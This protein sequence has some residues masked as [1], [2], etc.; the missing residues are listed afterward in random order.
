MILQVLIAMIAGWINRHQ[1]Q[2]IAYLLEEN[3]TLHAKLGDRRIR[4]TDA[5]RRR[6]AALAFPLG[7]KHLKSVATLAT[8]DTLMRWYKQL[9]AQK[10]DGSQKRN[11][12]GRPRVSDE[13]EALVLQMA[14]DNPTWGYRRIQGALA[15]LGHPIDK[16]TVRNILRR[17]H[18]DPAPN[19][20]QG[21]MSWSQFLNMHWEVLAATDF[22]T[23]EVATWHGLVTYYVFIVMEL[24]TR[25]VYL[26]G[27]TPHPDEAFMMQCAR[28][29]TDHV[30]GFLL[31]KRYLIHDRDTKFTAAFDQ[32]LRDQGV[33][34]LVLPPQSPNLNA[35]CGATRP[36]GSTGIG[37]CD[38]FMKFCLSS[39][40]CESRPAKGEPAR[41]G[42]KPGAALGN[43]TG[44]AEACERV[45]HRIAAP[46]RIFFPDAE[47]AAVE[48]RPQP[49]FALWGDVGRV[50][51]GVFDYSTHEEDGPVTWEALA[52][53]R[54]IPV[55]RRAGE[56]SPTHGA[57]AGA[58]VVGP[59]GTE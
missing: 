53:P 26:A 24:S 50:S 57:L 1:Q 20:R 59:R 14:N 40:G 32:Y 36:C 21:G 13:I 4:F 19:R 17:H 5:E 48:R 27:I 37:G 11:Q 39:S 42:S 47:T 56:L 25:R 38:A 16:I 34:P 10:F 49:S 41:A 23:V 28:Q 54:R 2:V 33:E 9:V 7:R 44:D 45:G 51:G 29:L 52:S 8:P 55:L 58:R 18:V 30:D 43:K 6:L 46:K 22:F 12:L 31:D 3:R 35:H 15:N